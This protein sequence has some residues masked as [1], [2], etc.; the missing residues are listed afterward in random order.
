MSGARSRRKGAAFE[1]ELVR[2]FREIMP[3]AGVRRGLQYRAGQ[4]A[5][6]VEV[7]CFW[8][9]AK[10]HHRTNVRAAM[11]QAIDACPPGRWPIAVCKDDHAT[12]LVTMQLEDFLELVGEWWERRDR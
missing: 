6:D 2:R 1:R 10:H 8:V 3:D 7:P 9:E 4:E 5:S 11:R 12:P